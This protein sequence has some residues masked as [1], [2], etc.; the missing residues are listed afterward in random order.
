MPVY[1]H[2]HECT[3]HTSAS[4]LE[5]QE[6]NL[7]VITICL[8]L[9]AAYQLPQN[10]K[11]LRT[12]ELKGGISAQVT[13]LEIELSS[14]QTKKMIVRQHGDMDLKYNQHIAANEFKLLQL[15]QSVG[16]ST[17]MPY[18]LD[19][20]GEI[21]STPISLLAQRLLESG[22]ERVECP[23]CHA[24]RQ[25][26]PRNGILRYPTHDKRKTRVPQT[27]PR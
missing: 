20:S 22:V 10:S 24:L 7:D 1:H 8:L 15:L 19:Q 6:K 21:F 5:E 9:L 4:G 12:W 14:R 23:D 13:A 18:H 16:L 25:I 26:T 3:Q 27:E 11:L 2:Q 17:P